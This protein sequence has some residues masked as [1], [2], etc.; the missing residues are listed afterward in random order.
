MQLTREILLAKR[1]LATAELEKL[2]ANANAQRGVI[3]TIDHL[4][5]VLDQPESAKAPAVPIAAEG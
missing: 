4:L 5:A 2:V 3:A 1:Q